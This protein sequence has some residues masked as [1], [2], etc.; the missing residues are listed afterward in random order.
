[1]K[2]VTWLDTTWCDKVCQWLA[3]GGWFST[4]HTVS[5]TN[6]TDHHDI[7]EILIT[8]ALN[9][10]WYFNIKCLFLLFH[11]EDCICWTYVKCLF[12]LFHREDC[13]CWTYV[14]L[15]LEVFPY[16]LSGYS[17]SRLLLTY[18]VSIIYNIYFFIYL[19]YCTHTLLSHSSISDYSM[20]FML[21]S[22]GTSWNVQGFFFVFSWQILLELVETSG[23]SFL[24]FHDKFYQH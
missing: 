10:K 6:K 8:I 15:M 12:L 23:G 18:M 14:T 9:L 5:S 24:C 11:R 2:P 21:N 1:M 7:T 4:G 22:I 3:A 20:I 17:N 16:C 13:I 19:T